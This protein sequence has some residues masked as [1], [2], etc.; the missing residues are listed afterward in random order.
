MELND[1]ISLALAGDCLLFT[2]AGFSLDARNPGGHA[3]PTA[4]Q[5]ARQVAARVDVDPD[6]SLDAIC[7][8]AI[9]DSSERGLGEHGL[10]NEILAT[11]TIAQTSPEQDFLASWPWR[12]VYTTNYDLSLETT[13]RKSLKEWTAI[14][15]DTAPNAFAQRCI[16][17][18]GHIHNLNI[19]NLRSQFKLTH[20]SYAASDF[21]ESPWASQFRADMGISP[22]IF[23]IGYSM[24]DIDVARVLFQS[25]LLQDRKISRLQAFGT[26]APIGLKAFADL[27]RGLS[28]APA[29]TGYTFS[30]LEQHQATRSPKAPSDQDT[31][32]LLTLGDTQADFISS[33]L[34][35]PDIK[36]CITRSAIADVHADIRSGRTWFLIH[37]ALGNGKTLLKLQLAETLANLN[38]SV[39][40]DTDYEL[41]RQQ[42][43]RQLARSTTKTAIMVDEASSRLDT[44]KDLRTADNGFNLFFV[45]V[46][47]TIFELD[48]GRFDEALP[49]NY[50]IMELNSL[51]STETRDLRVLLA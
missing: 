21:V 15:I 20:S 3:I 41:G 30:W 5:F 27:A 48:R 7:E 45:F 26:V 12:R 37:S 34:S 8:Y 2:G 19:V 36:Y 43:V 17:I 47:S 24:A 35:D 44:I 14:T 32:R 9:S 28:P 1:A 10:V 11:F 16:H 42:D 13:A 4:K 40:V 39:Y 46:R 6:Y 38:Y 25:P 29:A 18:N 23:F 31:I 22:A 49:E 50:R 33:A 51:D